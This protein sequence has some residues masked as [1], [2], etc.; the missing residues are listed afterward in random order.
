MNIY[1]LAFCYSIIRLNDTN[2][3][4]MYDFMTHNSDFFLAIHNLFSELRE[5][6]IINNIFY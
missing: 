3:K 2:T 6:D 4:D 5:K 1:K